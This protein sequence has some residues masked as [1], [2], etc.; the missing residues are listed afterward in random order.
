MATKHKRSMAGMALPAR[1]V[2]WLY[3]GDGIMWR[4][5]QARGTRNFTPLLPKK[6]DKYQPEP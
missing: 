5:R 2:L 3:I 1:V 6:K 4:L